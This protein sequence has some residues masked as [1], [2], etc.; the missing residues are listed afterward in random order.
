MD[1]LEFQA[2]A[3]KLLSYSPAPEHPWRLVF[4]DE[5][6][7]AY[8]YACD[9]RME[10]AGEGFDPTVIDAMLIYNVQALRS[11][12]ERTGENFSRKRLATVEWSRDG[13]KA[14]LRL[15]GR[16]QALID[17]AERKSYCQSNF[18]NFLDDGHGNWQKSSHAW[19]DAAIESFEAESYA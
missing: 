9:G 16:P 18:P 7:A 10:R 19:S 5:G 12:D 15:D 11:G 14:V 6:A 2:G 4:E 13:L 17:F 3:A 1:S 8:C